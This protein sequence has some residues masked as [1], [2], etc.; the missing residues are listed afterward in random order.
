MI[1]VRG[2]GPLLAAAVVMVA[3]LLTGCAT[4]SI[5][6][7]PTCCDQAVTPPSSLEVSGTLLV[8]GGAAKARTPASGGIVTFRSVADPGSSGAVRVGKDGEFHVY[9]TPGVYRVEAALSDSPGALKGTFGPFQIHS[10]H[11]APLEL[12][13]VAI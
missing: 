12:T 10:G 1:R 5:P 3:V 13:L 2:A 4:G 11:N 9:L 7:K 8:T 6:V